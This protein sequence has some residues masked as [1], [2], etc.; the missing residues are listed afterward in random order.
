MWSRFWFGS[1][2]NDCNYCW[3]SVIMQTFRWCRYL[4][5]Y[6]VQWNLSAIKY[7]KLFNIHLFKDENDWWYECKLHCIDLEA[8]IRC[9]NIIFVFKPCVSYPQIKPFKVY[10]SYLQMSWFIRTFE[11]YLH[12]RKDISHK[13]I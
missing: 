11:M 5:F 6:H 10:F 7:N 4:N 8:H 13:M 12:Y 2:C 3:V 9:F 1:N